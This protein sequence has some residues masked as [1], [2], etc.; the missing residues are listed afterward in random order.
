MKKEQRKGAV[1]IVTNEQRIEKNTL[2]L[3]K[4]NTSNCK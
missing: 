2:Y 4:N 3:K 1:I